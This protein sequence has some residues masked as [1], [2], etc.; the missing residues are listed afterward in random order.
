MPAKDAFHEAVK[1]ALIK[2]G[3]EIKFDPL[4]LRW[5]SRDF[6]VDLAASRFFLADKGEHR[7]AIEVKSFSASS[8]MAALEQTLGQFLIYRSILNR[9]DSERKLYLAVSQPVFRNIFE[10]DVGLLVREDYDIALVV[11]DL[12]TEVIIEWK[13]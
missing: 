11:F 4:H 2:D 6:Y 5:G 8:A 9:K 3:W 10:R 12:H 13:P 7:I 1:T